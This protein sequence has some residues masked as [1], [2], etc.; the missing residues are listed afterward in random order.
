MSIR[1]TRRPNFEKMATD[2]T[3]NLA[4]G[5]A[6]AAEEEITEIQRRTGKGSDA[7]NK[8]FAP[9]TKAYAE[10]RK[11]AGRGT[12]PNLIFKGTMLRAIRSKVTTSGGKVIAKIFLTGKEALKAK[13]N[14]RWRKFFAFGKDS[15]ARI[16]KTVK[17]ALR[18]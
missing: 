12:T 1:I 9:Y 3:K 17:E 13:G 6:R 16:S 8:K 5:M 14:M 15:A 4:V 18:S 2:L 11:E 10:K 7:D